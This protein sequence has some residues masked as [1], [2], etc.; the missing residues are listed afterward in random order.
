MSTASTRH[1]EVRAERIVFVQADG[2]VES[3]QIL[4]FCNKGIV[5]ASLSATIDYE[6]RDSPTEYVNCRARQEDQSWI[7]IYEERLPEEECFSLNLDSEIPAKRRRV[8]ALK[9]RRFQLARF[10]EREIRFEDP[11]Y[12]LSL[13]HVAASKVY[14]RA[15]IVFPRNPI[16]RSVAAQEARY[17]TSRTSVWDWGEASGMGKYLQM[18]AKATRAILP[19]APLRLDDAIA[20]AY[21]TLVSIALDEGGHVKRLCEIPQNVPDV[22]VPSG[23]RD[24]R[25]FMALDFE[26]Q[27]DQVR[28]LINALHELRER[29][30]EGSLHVSTTETFLDHVEDFARKIA[31][32]A[33]RAGLVNRLPD[34]CGRAVEAV[35][36][37]QHNQRHTVNHWGGEL[38]EKKF[39]VHFQQFLVSAGYESGR[40]VQIAGGRV[41]FLLGHTPVELKTE[42]LQGEP[43]IHLRK[44]LNQAAEYAAATGSGL[45]LLVVLDKHQY[46]ARGAYL[47]MVREQVQVYSVESE[48]GAAGRSHTVVACVVVPAFPPEPS[49]MGKN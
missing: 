4:E 3:V 40:E 38:D 24:E 5:P 30:M 31:R 34:D 15:A 36:R 25:T 46:R 22:N 37:Y 17:I 14:Y 43:S 10:G 32:E 41:D 42:D 29:I 33:R 1:L 11:Y 48:P 44:H 18:C 47:P 6:F 12:K 28:E 21:G 9:V 49:R 2:S 20:E 45:G 35:L 16:Y 26:E 8:V 7:P 27:M 23:L 13:S 19:A 39:Q